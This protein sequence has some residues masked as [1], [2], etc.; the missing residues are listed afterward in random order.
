MC[1]G[2][3]GR[4]SCPNGDDRSIPAC[5][6]EPSRKPR[7]SATGRG[8]SPRVRGNLRNDIRSDTDGRSIPACAGE[9]SCDLSMK[10][11]I[12]VYPRVCGGTRIF[13]DE[14]HTNIGLSPRVRGNPRGSAPRTRRSGSIP[15]CAGEPELEARIRWDGRVYPRVCGGTVRLRYGGEPEWGLSP[16]V[17]GNPYEDWEQP[18]DYGS[19]P[20]CA[21][22]LQTR[23][24]A[25]M[26]DRVYPRV[27]GGTHHT[28]SH[29]F[30]PW[31]LSPRVR[32]NRNAAATHRRGQGSIPA[33]AGEPSV[34]MTTMSTARVYPRVCGGTLL[35]AQSSNR[36][37]GLSPR[38]RGNLPIAALAAII[39]GS[40]PA[41]A[42]EPSLTGVTF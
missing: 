29:A 23:R 3:I 6:G 26:A 9:P 37:K 11:A 21:G 14:R 33:C 40:I 20:A 5:A 19:I 4:A 31:G 13:L 22:E 16:R 42:G 18:S 1:G 30:R 15:A 36:G 12:R 17:R 27:C 2:T 34:R 41:C 7:G 8:L 28:P 32:G 38:V 39:A 25:T 35:L 24:S 10:I